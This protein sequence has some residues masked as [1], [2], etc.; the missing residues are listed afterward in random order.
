M[1]M[2][3]HI[4][5]LQVSCSSTGMMPHETALSV[6]QLLATN[7]MPED[8]SCLVATSSALVGLRFHAR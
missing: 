6:S 1:C 8:E 2:V 5:Y 7:V 4:Y 3:R